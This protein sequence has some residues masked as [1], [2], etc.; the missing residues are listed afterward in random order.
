MLLVTHGEP[1]QRNAGQGRHESQT[2]TQRASEGGAGRER[3]GGQGRAGSCGDFSNGRILQ[4]A[5]VGQLRRIPDRRILQWAAARGV[6]FVR[7]KAAAAAASGSSR[8][9]SLARGSAAGHSA[10]STWAVHVGKL[11][12]WAPHHILAME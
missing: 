2:H 8:N 10:A 11:T 4:R 1:R 9:P 3:R 6:A 5:E 7:V 12:T